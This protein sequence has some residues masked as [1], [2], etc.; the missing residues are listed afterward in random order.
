MFVIDFGQLCF[1]NPSGEQSVLLVI[2]PKREYSS[3]D[4]FVTKALEYLEA[5]DVLYDD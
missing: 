5:N 2:G 1:N 4:S 3:M